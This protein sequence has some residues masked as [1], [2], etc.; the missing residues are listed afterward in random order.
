MTNA[1]E[2]GIMREDHACPIGTSEENFEAILLDGCLGFGLSVGNA[3][4]ILLMS[5][6]SMGDRQEGSFVAI[7]MALTVAFAL[8]LGQVATDGLQ[9][10][11][12]RR[13]ILYSQVI[14]YIF[15]IGLLCC[16]LYA[17][18]V[19]FGGSGLVAT[20]FL[21]GRFLSGLARK[22][23][24][25]VF[26]IVFMY[27]G[28]MLLIFSQLAFWY[29]LSILAVSVVLSVAI[30]LLFARKDY[31]F[32]DMVN[33]GESRARSIKVKGNNHT[34]L[35]LGFMFSAALMMFF[36][37][38]SVDVATVA[39]GA[40]VGLAGILSLLLGQM[41][42]RTYKEAL[43]KSMAF[44]AA[45]L[46]L[47]LPIVPE[48][49]KLVLLCLYTCMVSMNVIVMLN[50]IVETSRFDMIS[51]IWLFGQEGSV[52]FAGIFLGSAL[53]ATG[54]FFSGP[55]NEALYVTCLIAVVVSAW[56]Q[57]RVNYQIYPFEPIIE[58]KLDGE[59]QANIEHAGQRKTLWQEKRR[60][61]C[62]RYGL[63]PR[64]REILQ[65]L[66]KGRDAKYI[67]DTFYISQSTAKTH[68]YNIYRKF[69]IHSR[70]E[71]LDFVE[72]MELPSEEGVDV[73]VEH[74]DVV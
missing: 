52:F 18:S 72:D 71:L 14:A 21:Y 69:G 57:I 40:S 16:D 28:I 37:G 24:A 44:T 7:L 20:A 55:S 66:L 63:S 47:P 19:V 61:A 12:G 1:S 2:D 67:M 36:I 22:A 53:F 50:A 4:L 65:I 38:F 39:L 73:Q 59:T 31:P 17:L 27:V 48:T 9:G 46:L 51:P 58:T 30:S 62:E 3:V 60:L 10:D 54:G 32:S 23:L 33:A 34:L 43:K 45:F 6:T 70:Q 13:I 68:I 74:T 35:L 64:E 56:M 11:I 5:I 41:D 49:W 8:R 42:E 29:S 15:G 26:N 25:L